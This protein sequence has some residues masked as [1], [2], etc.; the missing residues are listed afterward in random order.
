MC[1]ITINHYYPLLAIDPPSSII[2]VFRAPLAPHHLQVLKTWRTWYVRH[3]LVM[4]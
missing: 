2:S 4:T 3:P 1:L